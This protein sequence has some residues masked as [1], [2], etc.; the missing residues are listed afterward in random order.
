MDANAADENNQGRWKRGQSGN[1]AGR[2]TGSRNKTTLA[3]EALLDGQGERLMQVCVNRALAGDGIALKLCLERILPVRKE[4][5]L[6]LTLPPLH[7]ANDLLEASKQVVEAIVTG[8]LLPSEG[9][10]IV[11]LIEQARKVMELTA[12]E[13]RLSALEHRA[14]GST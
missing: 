14:K 9:V 10:V 5:F 12:F 4:R 13:E 7:T 2:P 11:N 6:H 8:T 3:A 1:R